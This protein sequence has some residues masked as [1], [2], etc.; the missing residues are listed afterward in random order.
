MKG[1]KQIFLMFYFEQFAITP[2]IPNCIP[3]SFEPQHT[4]FP[5]VVRIYRSDTLSYF[6]V[7]VIEPSFFPSICYNYTYKSYRYGHY[8][9]CV[10]T[11]IVSLFDCII[12]SVV[13]LVYDHLKKPQFFAEKFPHTTQHRGF[14]VK[15]CLQ[16][17]ARIKKALPRV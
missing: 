4:N 8:F 2:I 16:Q 1:K 15:N 7:C 5:S 3:V 9:N 11:T 13:N 6:L 17:N 10:I 14:I 12:S